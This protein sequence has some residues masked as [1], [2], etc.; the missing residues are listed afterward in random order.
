[1]QVF[2][3]LHLRTT[4][5]D[6]YDK[7]VRTLAPLSAY[8]RVNHFYWMNI[9]SQGEANYFYAL[10]THIQWH[11]HVYENESLLLSLPHI[12][13]PQ[14]LKTEVILINDG[15]TYQLSQDAWHKFNV[16]LTVNVQTKFHDRVESY[17]FGVKKRHP[18]AT[19]SFIN[20]LPLLDKFIHHFKK[21]NAPLIKLAKECQVNISKL[22]K[23]KSTN[24]FQH[25]QH[26]EIKLLLRQLGLEAFE[27]LTA[28]ERELLPY[29]AHGYP[30]S[31]IAKHLHL[32]PRTV[33]NYIASIKSKLDCDS[34]TALIEKSMALNNTG[35]L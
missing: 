31:F 26:G 16:N 30:S 20:H 12:H 35:M 24:D 13:Y 2:Q 22:L 29:L 6:Q 21:E 25:Y 11:E 10:G 23:K 14:S 28:R 9:H 18:E 7:M 15:L 32:S 4:Q 34:K 17:G 3:E 8:F 27:D 19:Q 5:S 33:E 1:M